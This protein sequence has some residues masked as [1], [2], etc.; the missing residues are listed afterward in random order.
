M[1]NTDRSERSSVT[2]IA[3]DGD[4]MCRRAIPKL[5]N[6]GSTRAIMNGRALEFCRT[7]KN[8]TEVSVKGSHFLQ[9]DSPDEIG[10][11]LQQFMKNVRGASVGA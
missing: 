5:L 10:N 3:E 4:A 9:E 1:S 7:R 8:Q 11:A 6:G 2:A